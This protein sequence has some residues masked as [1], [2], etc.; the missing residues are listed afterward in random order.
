M[1]SLA[2][3][4]DVL[5]VRAHGRRHGNG[6]GLAGEGASCR[7]RVRRI[8]SGP[9]N[10]RPRAAAPGG[11][12]VLTGLPRWAVPA[13]AWACARGGCWPRCAAGPAAL[14]AGPAGAVP[15]SAQR[16]RPTE[17]LP[18]GDAP[19]HRGRQTAASSGATLLMPRPQAATADAPR[20]VLWPH[21][22]CARPRSPVPNRC[23]RTSISTTSHNRSDRPILLALFDPA[24]M[25]GRLRHLRRREVGPYQRCHGRSPA[26]QGRGSVP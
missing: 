10:K 1:P 16:R 11:G 4:R 22:P 6:A 12:P 25:N 19:G 21:S 3:A 23:W 24:A 7:A 17:H 5:T 13:G 18:A 8:S 15:G 20:A 26:H 2:A 14:T 9:S